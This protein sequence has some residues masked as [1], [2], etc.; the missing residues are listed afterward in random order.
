MLGPAPG[1]VNTDFSHDLDGQGV[2]R[3]RPGARAAGLHPS[4][5]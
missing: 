2:H 5:E 1:D 3:S 4:W